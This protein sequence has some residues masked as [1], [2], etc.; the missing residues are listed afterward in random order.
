MEHNRK[1]RA[2]VEVNQKGCEN[3]SRELE[4]ASGAE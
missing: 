3:V 1:A 4:L 2:R